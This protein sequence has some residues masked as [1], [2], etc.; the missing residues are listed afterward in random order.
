MS[1]LASARNADFARHSIQACA[2]EESYWDLLPQT[3]QLSPSRQS[4]G[5]TEKRKLIRMVRGRDLRGR[6]GW[7]YAI[8]GFELG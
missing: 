4:S 7:I 1:A 2:Q 6:E 3:R 5:F 8:A